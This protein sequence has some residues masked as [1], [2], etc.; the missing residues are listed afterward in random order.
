MTAMAALAL[1]ADINNGI[2]HEFGVG[3]EELNG[4]AALAAPAEQT[5]EPISE[6]FAA[7]SLAESLASDVVLQDILIGSEESCKIGPMRSVC[8]DERAWSGG[9]CVCQL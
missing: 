7:A 4:P 8:V 2:L 6:E 1:H 9:L 5:A 3:G